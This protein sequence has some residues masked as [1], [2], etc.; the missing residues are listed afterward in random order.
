MQKPLPVLE[1][2]MGASS[3]PVLESVIGAKPFPMQ[4]SSTGSVLCM[5]K[6]GAEGEPGHVGGVQQQEH[7]A[8]YAVDASFA[9]AAEPE[10]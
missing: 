10:N 7:C 4:R 8:F 1:S 2:V 9:A 5:V 3:L 6:L